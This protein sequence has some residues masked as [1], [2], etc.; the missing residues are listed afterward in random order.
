MQKR[1]AGSRAAIQHI[2][3]VRGGFPVLPAR[4]KKKAPRRGEGGGKSFFILKEHTDSA[5]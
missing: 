2:V 1:Q 4:G 5:S 3:C